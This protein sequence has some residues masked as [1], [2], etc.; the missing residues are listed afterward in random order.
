[1]PPSNWQK[2]TCHCGGKKAINPGG[3]GAESPLRDDLFLLLQRNLQ[4]YLIAAKHEPAGDGGAPFF[5]AAPQRSDL[6]G[7]E[8]F[9]YRC[10][11]P[12]KKALSSGIRLVN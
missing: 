5:D 11:K 8:L 1:M 7:L 10:L 9:R 6:A 3:L 4:P 2:Q 12:Q